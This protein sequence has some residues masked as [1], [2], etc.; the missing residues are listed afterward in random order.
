MIALLKALHIAAL[1]IWCA[2]LVL[3][4]VLMQFHGRNEI[5]RTQE[6]FALFRR[7]S[8]FSYTMVITPAAIIAVSAGTILI[9]ALHLVNAWMLAKLVAVAGMVLV[10]AWL[11]HLISMSGEGVG[12]YRMP[13][14]IIA[15][16]LGVP[17]MLTVLWLVL[18]KPDLTGLTAMLPEFLLEPQGHPL[19][20]G[21]TPI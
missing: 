10:H 17:L 8:H 7:L 15:L 6:G 2:G 14:P 13:P 3:L 9:I 18:A 12:H 11:G 19:P 21:F 1:S 20:D 5:A 4:P 16:L